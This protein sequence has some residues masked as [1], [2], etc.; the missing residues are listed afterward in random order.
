MHFKDKSSDN[1]DIISNMFGEYFSSKYNTKFTLFTN[2][3][4][5]EI[6]DFVDVSNL[7]FT[8]GE[9]FR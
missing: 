2:S 6:S 4:N 1:N 5:A 3:R 9:I 8:I 7:Q